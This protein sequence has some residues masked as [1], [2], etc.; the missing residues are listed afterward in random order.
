MQTTGTDLRTQR[1]ANGLTQQAVADALGVSR[2]TVVTWE[3]R[4]SVPEAR[5][6]AYLRVVRELA[7]R[8]QES[9]Q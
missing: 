1:E 3:Q 8:Q 4:A 6:A 2:Q 9:P 5:A 7:S